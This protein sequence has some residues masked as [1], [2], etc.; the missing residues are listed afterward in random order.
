[1]VDGRLV[2]VCATDYV[3]IEDLDAARRNGT[4][5]HLGIPGYAQ[6]ANNEHVEGE[7]KG[8]GYDAGDWHTAAREAQDDCFVAA[9]M[10]T[11]EFSEPQPG[12]CPIPKTVWLLA[13]P[14]IVAYPRIQRTSMED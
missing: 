3:L 4:K 13:H 1:M 9:L 6:L 14:P 10:S 7:T 12:I 8:R 11:K 2:E 5:R